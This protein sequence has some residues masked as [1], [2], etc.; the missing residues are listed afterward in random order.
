[1]KIKLDLKIFAL[2]ILFFLSGKG[3]SY[4]VLYTFAAIHE[5]GHI[6]MGI[7]L[8]LKPE[9]INI[10]PMG[11]CI[12]F[13]Q[14][15]AKWQT[16]LLVSI[17]GPIT[18]FIIATLFS[19]FIQVSKKET[20]IYANLILGLFNM[21]PVLPL[22]GGR[23]L[24]AI[25]KKYCKENIAEGII[26][27]TSNIAMALLTVIAGIGTLYLRNIAIPVI[28]IYLWVIVSNENKRHRLK[29]RIK[30]ILEKY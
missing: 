19:L 12:I 21:L 5:I 27:K 16:E 2:I 26:Y 9:R 1:M 24:M 3:Q 22:D 15:K 30:K 11:F 17:A 7:V 20:I 10:G 14:E 8:G 23:A 28:I 13:K 25:L 18:N 6:L 4:I 29:Q